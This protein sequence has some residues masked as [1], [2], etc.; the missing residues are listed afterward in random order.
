MGA[1]K[2][3]GGEAVSVAMPVSES[4]GEAMAERVPGDLRESGFTGWRLC[5]E[6]ERMRQGQ[7]IE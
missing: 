1:I 6:N 3:D 4:D 7:G 5:D 2:G